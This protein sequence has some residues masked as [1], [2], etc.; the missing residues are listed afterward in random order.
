MKPVEPGKPV[1]DNKPEPPPPTKPEP[2]IQVPEPE[3]NPTAEAHSKPEENPAPE[4][5]SVS[6]EEHPEA[7]PKF[8]VPAFLD[9]ARQIMREKS[10]PLIA[11]RDKDLKDNLARFERDAKRLI[12][13]I[14]YRM[15]RDA[16]EEALDDLIKDCERDG[17]RIPQELHGRLGNL[18]GMDEIHEECYEN[19]KT[20]DI[21]LSQSLSQFLP[22]YTM[23]LEKQIE[24]LQD[25]DDP[26]AI[27]AIKE[28]IDKT[29][30]DKTYF[31]NLMLGTE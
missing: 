28:E 1:S 18:H 15:A 5:P 20:I 19:Q 9:Q 16:A 7:L 10:A 25:E 11:K 22:T 26:A 27:E 31:P 21:D 13:K 2:D 4:T 24:R 12:R 6:E 29:R 3:K 23:G 30:D 8:D 17:N 14:E